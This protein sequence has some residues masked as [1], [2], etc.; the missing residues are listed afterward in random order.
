MK[1]TYIEPSTQEIYIGSNL[2]QTTS[3]LTLGATVNNTEG[4]ARE[5]DMTETSGSVWGEE[6]LHSLH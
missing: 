5:G 4:D 2:M 3:K 6:E 1:K